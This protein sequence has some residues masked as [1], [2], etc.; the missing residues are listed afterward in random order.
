MDARAPGKRSSTPLPCVG[1]QAVA[2]RNET[3]RRHRPESKWP[4]GAAKRGLGGGIL[5]GEARL[6]NTI[7]AARGNAASKSHAVGRGRD[8][9]DF[10]ISR[11]TRAPAA[12]RA[13]TGPRLCFFACTG[14]G[15]EKPA[16]LN[17][18]PSGG[19]VEESEADG[20]RA[21]SQTLLGRQRRTLSGA[22]L[23]KPRA[24]VHRLVPHIRPFDS[25]GAARNT[26]FSSVGGGRYPVSRPVD[27][28][29]DI[30]GKKKKKKN[31]K[32]KTSEK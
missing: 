9:N 13:R 7:G 11:S 29:Y 3:G 4:K 24:G 14:A 16:R 21:K 22:G 20:G 10:P 17:K 28:R 30:G 1:N 15:A 27:Q 5:A 26:S 32:K 2:G 25:N 12:P 23:E 18:L 6:P 8:G 19:N 31:K